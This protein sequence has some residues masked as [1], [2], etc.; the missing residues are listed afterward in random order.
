MATP[1][2]SHGKAYDVSK[3]QQTLLWGILSRSLDT[4]RIRIQR[5]GNLRQNRMADREGWAGEPESVPT[6]GADRRGRAEAH[7]PRL[8]QDDISW[9]AVVE[10]V[11]QPITPHAIHRKGKQPIAST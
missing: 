6:A 10:L 11:C 7:D 4:W 8:D 3:A 5:G 9:L 2:G 1:K